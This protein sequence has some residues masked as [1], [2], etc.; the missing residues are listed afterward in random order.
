MSLR[1]GRQDG[2]TFHVETCFERSPLPDRSEV[3]L[4]IDPPLDAPVDLESLE[5]ARASPAIR[6]LCRSLRAQARALQVA[7]GA[8]V[9]TLPAPLEDPAILRELMGAMLQL[10]QR[11]RGARDGG[12]YR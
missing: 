7:A 5:H 12:P 6:E 4:V 2:A 10:A 9:L 1:D 8:I 11:L 3:T